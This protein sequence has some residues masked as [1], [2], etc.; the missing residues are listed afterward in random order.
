MSELLLFAPVVVV[1]FVLGI[2]VGV[3]LQVRSEIRW[4][5]KGTTNKR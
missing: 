3:G 1:A 5:K 4:I 2:L